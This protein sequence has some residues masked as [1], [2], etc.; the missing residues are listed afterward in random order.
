MI[1]RWSFPFG[2]RTI[3]R[4]ELFVF[5]RVI[6]ISICNQFSVIKKC[7]N[8]SQRSPN[9]KSVQ[10][11][12]RKAR[13][14]ITMDPQQEKHPFKKKTGFFQ[15]WWKFQLNIYLN[16]T[17]K[18]H[19]ITRWYLQP[20]FHILLV[21]LDDVPRDRGEHWKNKK[22]LQ[23]E[24]SQCFT[25]VSPNRWNLDHH[26]RF[27]TQKFYE[28]NL[29]LWTHRSP[30]TLSKERPESGYNPGNHQ[31]FQVPKVEA[32]L[33]LIDGAILGVGWLVVPYIRRYKEYPYSLYSWGFLQFLGSWTVCWWKINGGGWKMT[34]PCK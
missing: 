3:F 1:G 23:L 13:L 10:L 4:G 2:F 18:N 5:G 7:C 27:P 20:M 31:E 30:W 24:T 14:K 16:F 6:T 11:H 12:S 28:R 21:K 17:N 9:S 32:F 25:K 29:W 15:K 34:F 26:R 8:F 19:P 22:H 33:N